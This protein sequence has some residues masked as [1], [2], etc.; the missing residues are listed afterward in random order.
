MKTHICPKCQGR[1]I[2]RINGTS[3]A[4]G[5]GNNIMVGA[6]IFSVVL[7]H[8]YVCCK[9]GYSEEWIDKEDIQKLQKKYGK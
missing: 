4:Y 7:V 2:I 5:T 3:G 8:R 6:T 1:D 9:C